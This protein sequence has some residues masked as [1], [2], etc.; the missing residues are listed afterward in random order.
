MMQ[1]RSGEDY[2][3]RSFKIYTSNIIV[4][5]KSRSMRW[6]RHVTGMGHRRGVYRVLVGTPEGNKPHGRSRRRWE[7]I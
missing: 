3:T 2:T 1:Q 6:A 4:V 7:N 5:I